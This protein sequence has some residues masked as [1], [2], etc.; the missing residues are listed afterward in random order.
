MR[1]VNTTTLSLEEFHDNVPTYAVLSHT[2][3]KNETTYE[4]FTQ[5]PHGPT[6][7]YA[8]IT[9]VCRQARDAGFDYCWIDTCCIA[10]A[11]SAELTEAINSMFKWYKEAEVCFVHLADFD[12]DAAATDMSMSS[13]LAHCR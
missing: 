10:K 2:W 12:L 9:A 13:R 6:Q 7:G 1:L 11:S 3:E 5:S 8:K 4:E